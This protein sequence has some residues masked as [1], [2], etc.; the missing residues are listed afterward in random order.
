MI[1][2]HAAYL[3]DYIASLHLPRFILF[4]H[5]LGGAVASRALNGSILKKQIN[6]STC[7]SFW[8]ESYE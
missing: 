2:A 4:G 8:I 1:T 5:S 7:S 6:F 3:L